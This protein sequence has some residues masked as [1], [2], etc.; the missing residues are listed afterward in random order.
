[1]AIYTNKVVWKGAHL[2]HTYCGND[3]D[4]EFSAPPTLQ[5]HPKMMTPEDALIMA[6]NTCVH[7][8]VIWAS[9]RFKLDMVSYECTATGEVEEFIDQTSWFKKITLE[10]T[11]SVRGSSEAVVKRALQLAYKYSTIAQSVKSEVVINP[12][13]K[14]LA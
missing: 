6:V 14:I 12:V 3:T 9:E 8:M 11:I 10:P 4:M 1:M 7:M 13:I 2:G 5:G